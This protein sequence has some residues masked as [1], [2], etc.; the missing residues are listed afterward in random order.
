MKHTHRRIEVGRVA[1]FGVTA[2]AFV[3]EK[4]YGAFEAFTPFDLTHEFTTK[5]FG[6]ELRACETRVR[7]EISYP[8]P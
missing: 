5:R 8:R 2:Y 6:I 3:F 1:S 7:A 4:T